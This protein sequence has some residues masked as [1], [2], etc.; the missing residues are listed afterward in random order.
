ML[1]KSLKK[2]FSKVSIEDIKKLREMTAAPMSDCKKALME[3]NNNISEAKKILI[4]KNLAKANKKDGREQ[5]EGLWGFLSNEDR[6]RA[7]LLNLT[8][9]TDFVAKS[10]DFIKFCEDSLRIILQNE[11][12]LDFKGESEE[13]KSWLETI[14]FKGDSSLLEAKKLLIANTEENIEF[15]KIQTIEL[16]DNNSIIGYYVH[17]TITETTGATGSL[18][19]LNTSGHKEKTDL[20]LA[21]N[22]AVH[23]FS[24]KPKYFYENQIPREIYETEYTKVEKEM[25][26]AI[27]GKPQDIVEK[28]LRGKFMKFLEEQEVMEFQKLGFIDSDETIGEYLSDYQK[29]NGYSV[30]IESYQGFE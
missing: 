15:S 21:D 23:C 26:R 5:K 10:Q 13:V 11:G 28:I 27:K 18:V 25:E 4:K 19:V 3:S 16:E 14:E 2:L 22:L 9:E 1:R 17:K 20:T 24:M 8:C 7:V 12:N 6:S 30:Q 29:R